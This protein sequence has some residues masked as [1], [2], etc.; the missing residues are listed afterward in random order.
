MPEKTLCSNCHNVLPYSA[1][2]HVICQNCGDVTWLDKDEMKK[3]DQ[4]KPLKYK[5]RRT[6]KKEREELKKRY[7]TEDT[8]W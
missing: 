6:T 8:E 2:D 7:L 3:E 5:V 1:T 4:E